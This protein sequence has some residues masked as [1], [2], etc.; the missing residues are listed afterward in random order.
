M[1]ADDTNVFMSDESIGELTNKINVELKL[2]GLDFRANK[3]HYVTRFLFLASKCYIST[4][5]V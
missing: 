5:Y 2:V 1:V 4:A 3:L